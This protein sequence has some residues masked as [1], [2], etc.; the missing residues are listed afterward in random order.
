MLDP[1]LTSALKIGADVVLEDDAPAA[2]ASFR[3]CINIEKHVRSPT[4]YVE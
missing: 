3:V 1:D 2:N 4:M